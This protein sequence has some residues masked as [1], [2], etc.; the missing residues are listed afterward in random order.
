MDHRQYVEHYLSADVD[1]E[2]TAPERQ[3]VMAHLSTCA[4][5]RQ[6]QNRERALKSLLRE[7]LPIVATPPDVRASVIAALDREAAPIA[8]KPARLTRRPLW[9]GSIAAFAAAAS[10]IAL[11][12]IRGMGPS[13]N[14]TFEAAVTDYLQSEQHFTPNAGLHSV[15]ELAI[16]LANQFGYPYVWIS[17]RSD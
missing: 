9:I 4:D 11:I 14:T 13:P 15:D 7:R 10:I 1:G 17:P 3:A 16:A 6:R 2:L 5:C 8:L 12:L